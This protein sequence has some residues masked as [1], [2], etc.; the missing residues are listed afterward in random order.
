MIGPTEKYVSDPRLAQ[1]RTVAEEDQSWSAQGV[2]AQV[3]IDEVTGMQLRLMHAFLPLG[4]AQVWYRRV[5]VPGM[6]RWT[7]NL[8]ARNGCWRSVV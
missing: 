6:P 4:K 3:L 2:D 5:E 7:P 1:R 8:P